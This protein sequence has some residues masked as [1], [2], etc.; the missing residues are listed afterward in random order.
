M[1]HLFDN[2]SEIRFAAYDLV[3]VP[4]YRSRPVVSQWFGGE[5]NE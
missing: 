4:E 5:R 3:A 1:T 2:N